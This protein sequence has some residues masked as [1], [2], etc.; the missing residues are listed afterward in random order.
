MVD[1]LTK[2]L[3]I[4][5]IVVIGVLTAPLFAIFPREER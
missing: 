4:I 2:V 1:K 3:L 5:A